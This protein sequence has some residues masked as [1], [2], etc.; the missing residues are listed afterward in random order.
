LVTPRR[1]VD[2]T[3]RTPSTMV[4]GDAR[5]CERLASPGEDLVPQRVC[6]RSRR[7]VHFQTPAERRDDQAADRDDAPEG[8]DTAAR[9]R[10]TAA[11]SRDSDAHDR[12]GLASQH[13]RDLDER[14]RQVC[15]QIL[16]R[17]AWAEN[18]TINPADWP[19]LTPAALDRLRAHAA[20]QR[21]LTA[22]DRAIASS[23]LADLRAQLD[24]GRAQLRTAADDRRAAASDRL[25]SDQDRRSAA[26]DRDNSTRDRG[27]AALEREQADPRNIV[28]AQQTATGVDDSLT[29]RTARSV[30]ESR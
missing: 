2:G 16:D 7:M 27:Q 20:E 12:D 8:C 30:A 4:V 24:R 3:L 14:L 5:P 23:L 11:T 21:C 6:R 18:T 26:Q 15:Q 19:D 22:L 10:D 13:P 25:A 17:L 1:P 29:D 9:D 28:A